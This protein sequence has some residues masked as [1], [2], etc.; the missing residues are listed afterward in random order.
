MS[1]IAMMNGRLLDFGGSG[2]LDVI[3]P[4]DVVESQSAS[5]HSRSVDGAEPHRARSRNGKPIE[6]HSCE[7]QAPQALLMNQPTF[8]RHWCIVAELHFEPNG[9]RSGSIEG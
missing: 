1:S 9:I 6:S 2:A 5:R 8:P 7:A 3:E 4:V